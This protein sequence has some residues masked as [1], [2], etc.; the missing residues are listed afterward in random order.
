MYADIMY[1]VFAKR[2]LN[3]PEYLRGEYYKSQ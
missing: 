1:A 2:K 3:T